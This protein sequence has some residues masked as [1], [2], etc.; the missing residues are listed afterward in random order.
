MLLPVGDSLNYT[1][2]ESASVSHRY[3]LL[4]FEVSNLPDKWLH[5][6][7]MALPWTDSPEERMKAQLARYETLV[8]EL[9]SANFELLQA[10]STAIEDRALVEE[11]QAKVDA[12]LKERDGLKDGVEEYLESSI[13]G[14]L[15]ENGLNVSGRFI[16]PP[17]D[18]RLD[19]PPSVLII[20]PRDRISRVETILIDPDIPAED[21][22]RIESK[23]KEENNLSAVVLRTGGLASYPT[24]IPSDR[25][26]LPLL[27]VASHEWLHAYL[28]FHP[29]GRSFWSGGEM[30]TIN[31]TLA[32]LFG[33]EIGGETWAKLTGNPVPVRQPPASPDDP[34]V[35]PVDP[36]PSQFD[37]S[38]FMRETRLRADELLASG[39]IDGAEAWMEERRLE[40]QTHGYVIRKIN[41]AYFAFT[42]SYADSPGSVSPVARQ[43]WDLRQREDS[44]GD[45]V[46][47]LQGIS[48]Y[49]QFEALLDEHGITVGR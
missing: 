22:E 45:L 42:G 43:I 29:L 3:A 8:A 36:D 23:L 31:E 21:M 27:E 44:M 2:A 13:S 37:F 5:R 6:I 24:V 49:S 19:N 12:L 4:S 40:L 35:E 41:Q 15:R 11:R 28:F 30:V 20:S 17:V 16:W 48:T 26:L 47:A 33:D 7:Y 25:D 9:R 32:N 14:T 38:K 1:A 39:D 10:T 46:E 34:V 18:F